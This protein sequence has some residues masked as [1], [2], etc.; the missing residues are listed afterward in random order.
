MH[1]QIKTSSTEHFGLIVCD[2]PV[3]IVTCF[4]WVAIMKSETMFTIFNKIV[5]F[6]KNMLTHFHDFPAFLKSYSMLAYHKN[7]IG[8]V[9]CVK[10]EMEK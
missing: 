7:A 2:Y 6:G 8:V 1:W 10:I 9:L 4:Q 5:I 3:L